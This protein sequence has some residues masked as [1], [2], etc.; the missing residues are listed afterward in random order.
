MQADV[1]TDQLQVLC[2]LL[3]ERKELSAVGKERIAAGKVGR[4][5]TEKL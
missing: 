2:Q 1:K 3:L 4:G 5:G